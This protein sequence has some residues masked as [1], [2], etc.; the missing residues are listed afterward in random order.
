M[1]II[2]DAD[3]DARVAKGAGLFDERYPGWASHI[4]RDAL[5]VGNTRYCAAA[6]V[7]CGSSEDDAYEGAMD[8]LN[9]GIYDSETVAFGF[10]LTTDEGIAFNEANNCDGDTTLIYAPL[11]AAWHRAINQ[12]L[13]EQP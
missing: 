13:K 2:T 12:R 11:T 6:Q 10:I 8:E 9:L 1:T 3:L 5:D 4:N 7:V